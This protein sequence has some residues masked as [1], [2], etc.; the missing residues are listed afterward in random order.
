[1]GMLGHIAQPSSPFPQALGNQSQM[2]LLEIAQPT[3]Q[4][5]GTRAGGLLQAAPAL[6][7]LNSPAP[8]CKLPGNAQT[9]DAA[10]DHAN[11]AE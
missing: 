10:A 6:K 11:M 2:A 7:Q 8:P 3:M 4:Q 1:M 5:L 9:I